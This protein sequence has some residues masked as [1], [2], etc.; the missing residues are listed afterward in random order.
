[1]SQ[2]WSTARSLVKDVT[3]CMKSSTLSVSFCFTSI[4]CR[5]CREEGLN[6]LWIACLIDSREVLSE[7]SNEKNSQLLLRG[8]REEC[9]LPLL[10]ILFVVIKMSWT[11]TTTVQLMS[12]RRICLAWLSWMPKRMR[13]GDS[14]CCNSSHSRSFNLYL[15]CSE[16][17][18]L[19]M[20]QLLSETSDFFLLSLQLFPVPF[21]VMLP[22]SLLLFPLFQGFYGSVL[23]LKLTS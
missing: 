20:V 14:W 8:K 6:L 19:K 15:S 9:W 7:L 5:L 18:G 4:N 3:R 10:Q 2:S 17:S 1:M 16:W 23:L 22:S 21:V 13:G 12:C 11:S